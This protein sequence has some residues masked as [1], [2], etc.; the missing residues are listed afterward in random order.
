MESVEGNVITLINALPED[1][2]LQMLDIR[3]G[4]R[5]EEIVAADTYSVEI[6]DGKVIITFQDGADLKAGYYYVNVVDASG[7]YRS[8]ALKAVPL[9]PRLPG[10]S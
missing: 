2:D 10:S 4:V 1:F 6:A 3:W 5:N 9:R 8:P 7:K